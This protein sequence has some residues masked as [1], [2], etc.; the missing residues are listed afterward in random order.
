MSLDSGMN[1]RAARPRGIKEGCLE[2]ASYG[3]PAARPQGIIKFKYTTIY[4]FHKAATRHKGCLVAADLQQT[5][6]L[7]CGARIGNGPDCVPIRGRRWSFLEYSFVDIYGGFFRV[8]IACAW[9]ESIG[10]DC[11]GGVVKWIG[12]I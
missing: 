8:H 10:H 3:N 1:L 5:H 12:S 4:L 2:I 9:T 7:P 6:L 11:H